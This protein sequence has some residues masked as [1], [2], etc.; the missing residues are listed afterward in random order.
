MP[1]TSDVDGDPVAISFSNLPSYITLDHFKGQ[2]NFNL[3]NFTSEDFNNINGKLV[4]QGLLT[5]SRN[6]KTSFTY[7]I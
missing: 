5:D 6:G 4:L 1:K 2:L 7:N 3:S